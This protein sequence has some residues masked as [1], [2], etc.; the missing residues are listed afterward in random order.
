[1]DSYFG[2]TKYLAGQH[3]AFANLL[4]QNEIN[5]SHKFTVGLN[6]TFD[7]YD[8]D[9]RRIVA[10]APQEQANS[11]LTNLANAGVFGEYTFHAGDK[12]SAIAGLRGDWYVHDG[13]KVSPRV[14]LKYMPID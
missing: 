11:G 3:S 8:E 9:F 10:A 5:E 1:M 12:F 4:Y 6:G 14:T 13:F 7:R 2:A